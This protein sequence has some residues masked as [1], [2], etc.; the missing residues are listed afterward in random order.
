MTI[1]RG[2][3]GDPAFRLIVNPAASQ[4]VDQIGLQLMIR[5]V[6]GCSQ[7]DEVGFGKEL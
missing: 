1:E 6:G 2:R 3:T 7:G 4:S 5:F